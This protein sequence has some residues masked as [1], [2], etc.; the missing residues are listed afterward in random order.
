MKGHDIVYKMGASEY[1]RPIYSFE[2]PYDSN[3]IDNI[4]AKYYTPIIIII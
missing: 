4:G 3:V 1:V 2:Y